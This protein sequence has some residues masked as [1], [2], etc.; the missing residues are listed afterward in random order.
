MKLLRTLQRQLV[1]NILR[2]KFWHTVS[3]CLFFVYTESAKAIDPTP[4]HKATAQA[5]SPT[6]GRYSAHLKKLY[7]RTK[8]PFN[9]KW[10]PSP[11][12]EIIKLA[13][14]KKRKRKTREK[15]VS[16][17]RSSSLEEYIKEEELVPIKLDEIL[18]SGDD[19]SHPNCVIV[20]GAPGIG[21]STFAWQFSQKWAEGSLYQE[22]DLVVLLQMRNPRVREA[23]TLSDL[24]NYHDN[25]AVA[26]EIL[27]KGGEGVLLLFEGID[28][29]PAAC[30]DEGSVFMDLFQ[31]I[32]LPEAT[33][34][35]T[36]RPWAAEKL[37][38]KCS[39][40]ISREI[41]V[42][43]FGKD[44]IGLYASKS[45]E[46][47]SDHK[48]FHQYF[49]TH[50]LLET[51]MY[52]PLNAAIVVQ[53]YKQ[54]KSSAQPPPQTMT[55]LYRSLVQGLVLRCLREDP[56]YKELNL[57]SLEQLPPPLWEEFRKLCELAHS[58]FKED[59]FKIVFSGSELPR[60]SLGIMQTTSDLSADVGSVLLHSFPHITVQEFLAAYHVSLLPLKEQA[61]FVFE[62]QSLP[63]FQVV[64]FGLSKHVNALWSYL[65]PMSVSSLNTNAQYFRWLYEA[66]SPEVCA[67]YIGSDSVTY[68]CYTY[69]GS[70]F[71]FFVTTYCIVYSNCEWAIEIFDLPSTA[72]AFQP[73]TDSISHF[74]GSIVEL[75]SSGAM[76][77]CC[78]I[79]SL[80]P[81]LL[82]GLERLYISN[83]SC[84][85]FVA[86]IAAKLL[87][88]LKFLAIRLCKT[89]DIASLLEAVRLT[90]IPLQTLRV[91]HVFKISDSSLLQLSKLVYNSTCLNVLDIRFISLNEDQNL[92]LLFSAM[93]KPFSVAK[94]NLYR[95]YLSPTD[96]EY[97]SVVLSQNRNLTKL[98]LITCSIDD[99][100]ASLMAAALEE[101]TTLKVLAFH[102][103]I[104][105]A[106]AQALADML[107][108]NSA[109]KELG[110]LDKSIGIDGAIALI[111]AL[112]DNQNLV[113]LRLNKDCRPF[114]FEQVAI[115]RVQF[116]DSFTYSILED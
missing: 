91:S 34:L 19:D 93:A 87:P 24:I 56:K 10:P 85:E 44:D 21:K 35:A 6:L 73:P 116:N 79:L 94:L 82:V 2:L 72:V 99:D 52:I 111:A 70:S 30:L 36:T 1:R 107:R 41:E 13:A 18:K 39:E 63:Q 22:Y 11:C 9:S 54:R 58:A 109:L 86:V 97:L 37:K 112:E 17:M 59:S 5:L 47:E 33:I 31:G 40:Q 57:S 88:N 12:K 64:L 60:D 29:L 7:R 4:A 67:A 55:Q 43:G 3:D 90:N 26:Q 42:L 50:P 74:Q 27:E 65:S 84:D 14:V 62:H 103:K 49:L 100:G 108:I 16:V 69:E 98:I 110:V 89:G 53:V 76:I 104:T 20:Q 114:Q 23:K 71:D 113:Q 105:K 15:E 45:F 66:Q 78:G 77:G 81:R 61:A 25:K 38:I 96:M 48:E 101:N 46:E 80:P 8:H 95:V 106:G 83:Q 115:D 28:E 92:H 102:N 32:L 68:S 51:V 75:Q